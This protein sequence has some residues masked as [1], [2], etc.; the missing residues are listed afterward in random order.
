MISSPPAVMP[1]PIPAISVKVPSDLSSGMT[2]REVQSQT[3][4]LTEFQ[5]AVLVGTLL[6]DGSIAKHGHHHRLFI[7]HA[8]AQV[9]LAAWKREVFAG[10]T[11]MPLHHFDQRLNDRLYP[12]VQFVTR[13]YPVFSEWRHR[14]YREKRK[15]VPDGVEALLGPAAVAAWFM[16]DGTADRAGVSFQTQSFEVE[17]VE[18]LAAALRCRYSLKT[19]LN[20]NKGAW[21]VY[22]HGSSV[23]ALTALVR[24]HMLP[25]LAYKLVPRGTWTP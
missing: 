2:P 1:V 9:A 12:C 10:F 11:S 20:R 21:V 19:S 17:E 13:T 16:D 23:E 7:K 4:E 22:V 18:R 5:Q 14:F 8:V 25:E 15:I 24:E 3:S 6:G